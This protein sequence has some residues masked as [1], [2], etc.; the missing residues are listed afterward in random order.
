MSDRVRLG[1]LL[2]ALIEFAV[3]VCLTWA[4]VI[5]IV[6]LTVLLNPTGLIARI[7]TGPQS[8]CSSAE[9]AVK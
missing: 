3:F 4:F 7:A 5:G 6:S 1:R 2:R 8:P 9:G